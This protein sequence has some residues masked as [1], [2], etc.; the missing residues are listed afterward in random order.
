MWIALAVVLCTF[1]LLSPDPNDVYPGL[2]PW[3][4]G[5][6]LRALMTALS[7]GGWTPTAR[8]IEIKD[9]AFYVG[10]ALAL[11]LLAAAA[12][13]RVPV[14]PYR[15]ARLALTGAVLLGTWVTVSAF[16]ATWS[17]DASLSLRQAAL[18]FM[19]VG[20][21]A[22]LGA[23]LRPPQ[24]RA[25]LGGLLAAGA[26]AAVLCI[27]YF[28]ERSPNHRPGFPIGNPGTL[29]ATLLPAILV[30]VCHVARVAFQPIRHDPRA[31]LAAGAAAAALI[32][33]TWCLV[34]T[35]ARAAMI[36]L[37][38]GVAT[39]VL[40]NV[41]RR[42]RYVL[43]AAAVLAVIGAALAA[44]FTPVLDLL[45]RSET[46]RFRGYMWRYAAELWSR[47][48]VSGVGAASFARLTGVLSLNDRQL[49]P[50]AFLGDWAGHAHNE[51][52]EV[53][54]EIGLLGGV[55]F[56][57]GLLASGLALYRLTLR[58]DADRWWRVAI[59][60]SLAALTTEMLFNV[61][62]RLPGV[63]AEYAVLL[64]L[65][66]AACLRDGSG[67]DAES[68]GR[69][70]G[71]VARGAIAGSAALL[72]LAAGAVTVVNWS[73]VLAERAAY[74]AMSDSSFAVALE[75]AQRARQRLFDPLRVLYAEELAV[76]ARLAQARAAFEAVSSAPAGGAGL[77][78]A[79]DA[80][81][82][83]FG[84][85]VALHGRAPTLSRMP[86]LA[87]RAAEMIVELL[88]ETDVPTASEW[89]R[90]AVEAWHAQRNESPYDEEALLALLRYPGTGSRNAALLRDALRSGF[91]HP[92]W[93][94]ALRRVAATGEFR[95]GLEVL[96]VEAGPIDPATAVDSI[97]ASRAP[98]T[99]RLAAAVAAL[100]GDAGTAGRFAE[101]AA[102]LYRS[103]RRRL[104]ELYSVARAEQAEYEFRADFAQARQAAGR[105]EEAIAALPRIQAQHYQAMA[106]PYRRRL[107]AYLLAAGDE[108][109]GRAVVA[110]FALPRGHTAPDPAAIDRGLADSYVSLA[111]SFVRTPPERRP[112]L[113]GWLTAALRRVPAHPRAWWLRAW[114][115]AD[116]GDAARV[117]QL[118]AEAARTG[119]A[120]SDVAKMRE[121]LARDFPDLRPELESP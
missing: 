90:R 75:Q 28:H 70:V 82:A 35:G 9:L 57:G 3:A 13:R 93:H 64:G 63:P 71:P 94:A 112:P 7:L 12:A 116:S 88:R 2:I 98:E 60:A 24:I 91:P 103:L 85:A 31:R 67:D 109:A 37:A 92:E 121:S 107:A 49:D 106:E 15:R 18:Y 69:S 81:G 95:G 51:L 41:G 105:V 84:A 99:F 111:E 74:A 21:A 58:R 34:L 29:A 52:F 120:A 66:W 115:A 87:A 27:W 22:A 4:P 40:V 65:G 11:A 46:I 108:T 30:A 59:L 23:T 47:R 53:F 62:L 50:A 73:G 48:P 79:V 101:R 68:D 86:A 80:A 78:G 76:R 61:S 20:G 56:V 43:S 55:T 5:S 89:R 110:Q 72:S 8:G 17:G 14:E 44:Y 83:A 96:L 113:D 100:D 77:Q 16:S 118:L 45:D 119:V 54:A 39:L 1:F 19:I 25:V 104:P 33:L 26:A 32:P 117:R 97:I 10:V 114:L 36:G 42:T 6:A 38:A 102:T